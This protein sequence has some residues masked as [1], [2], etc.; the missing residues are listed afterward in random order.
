[1]LARYSRPDMVKIW[2]PEAKFQRWLEIEVAACEA[3]AK[4][5]KI[6]A[7]DLKAIQKKAKFDIA[8]IEAIEAI[9]KHDVIAFVSCVAEFVGPSGRF[10]HMGLTSSDV[11]DSCLAL[12]LRDAGK[13]L[14]RDLDALLKILKK[15][16]YE[17]KNTL[18][19]GRS[20]GIHAE[21]ITFGLKLAICYDEM[22]R[23]RERL[24][25]AI[26]QISFG[27]CSGAVGTFAHAPPAIEKYVM[28]KL[29]L[30]AAPASS[31]I[32]QRDRHAFYFST[33]AVIA[34]S[35]EKIATEIRHLQRSEVLE[36][37]E[38]FSPGQKGSSAMPHKR[39]PVLSEN[40]S[41]LAR[42]MRGY[43]VAALENQALWHERDISHSSVE[44]VIGPDA[45]VTLDFM[46][47]RLT[48]LLENLIVYPE[49]MKEN[50]AKLGGLV[51][52]Q[53][54]LLALVEAGMRREDAYAVVQRNA[55]RVWE[56]RESFS[57]L[58]KKEAQVRKHLTEQAI[59]G[60][61]DLKHHTRHVESIFKRVFGKAKI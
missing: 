53:Q 57:A 41:G 49:R 4:L 47:G 19:V 5:G 1:M 23:N 40:L 11:L 59:D 26:E 52:S 20:H 30:K 29:G 12:Q 44:R 24:E 25:L 58:L 48:H 8:R 60:I 38:Y 61:F 56:T 17:H 9:T 27:K 51:H 42:L 22:R 35:I 32:V 28:K 46:L 54:V 2:E 7:A 55:M 34:G 31:Q 15:R 39:N 37:E 3:W 43:S 21:P 14:L 18:Q 33:L 16:A 36:A 50:L 10:L 6:P 45:T 13:I